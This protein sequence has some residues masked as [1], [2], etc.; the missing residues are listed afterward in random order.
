MQY[1]IGGIMNT[2]LGPIPLRIAPSFWMIVAMIA[3]LNSPSLFGMI[4]WSGIIVF[5]IV[6]HELGHAVTAL[7]FGQK[8][9]IHLVTLGGL[10]VR[11]GAP[12][13]H[14]REF[15]VVLMGPM[16]GMLL[17]VLSFYATQITTENH[18]IW[19]YAFEVMFEVNLFWT[20]LNLCPVLP[21]DGGQL[22]RIFL[23][24]LFGMKGFKIASWISLILATLGGVYFF[25]TAQVLIGAIFLMFGFDSYRLLSQIKDM[26]PEDTDSEIRQ[27]MEKAISDLRKNNPHDALNQFLMVRE[28]TPQGPL[29]VIATQYAAKAL[30]D[31]GEDHEAFV[32]LYPLKKRISSESFLLLL[33]V[34]YRSKEWK[35]ALEIGEKAFNEQQ[36]A[37]V[38][39]L[40]ASI[41]AHL[42][43]VDPSVGWLYQAAKL[44]EN[45]LSD[46]IQ[47]PEFDNIRNS[48]SFQ[49]LIKTLPLT[50]GFE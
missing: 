42:D 8:S 48:A 10:T 12:I 16:A 25:I 22:L 9:E 28:K 32:L 37:E 49:K 46:I 35:A 50:I 34:A 3:Y 23:E 47:K 15:L 7:I 24:S 19:L 38:A 31:M 1:K 2:F 5:S 27:I 39:L 29:Y 41:S 40:N 13:S 6:T 36:N 14:G 43:L 18:S 17:C 11:K 21:L 20:L 44:G 4:I 45:D 26:V 33:Q 30:A